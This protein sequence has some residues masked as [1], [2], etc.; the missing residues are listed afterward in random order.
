MLVVLKVL[1]EPSR[2]GSK[3]HCAGPSRLGS[4]VASAGR[5]RRLQREVA[6][7]YM[8][9]PERPKLRLLLDTDLLCELAPGTEPAA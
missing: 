7:G 5:I 1:S 4:R 3:L 9:W 2:P 8:T 6:G